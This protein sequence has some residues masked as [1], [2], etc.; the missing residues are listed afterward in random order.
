MRHVRYRRA[1]A[2]Y[3]LRYLGR[4]AAADQAIAISERCRM[5]DPRI[6]QLAANLLRE[7]YMADELDA[8]YAARRILVVVDEWLA[9]GE[10]ADQPN[11]RAGRARSG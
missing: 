8:H 3:L 2:G 11:A 7:G 6:E 5:Y 9:E 1:W 4:E 10:S